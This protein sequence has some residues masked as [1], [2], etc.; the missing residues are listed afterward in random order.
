MRFSK[1]QLTGRLI[2]SEAIY[3]IYKHTS[4][5]GKSYIGQTKNLVYR[6]WRHQRA[7]SGCIAFRNAIQ[8]YG[9]DNFTHEILAEGITLDEANIQEELFI[10][11]HN[12]LF[13]NGYNIS[14]GGLNRTCS[15]ETKKKISAART[16]IPRSE[17]TKRKIGIYQASRII[18]DETKQKISNTKQGHLVSDE[19]KQKIRVARL[20]SKAS[21]E[22]LEKRRQSQLLRPPKINLPETREKIRASKIGKPRSEE[23]KQKIRETMLRKK[24]KT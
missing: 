23:T 15:N 9:W 4:P 17:E 14:L 8:K 12:T 5:S 16:G 22:S 3:L 2:M 6:S 7:D 21:P 24:E 18:S 13:P 1:Q 10:L 19:T 11:E 20:G